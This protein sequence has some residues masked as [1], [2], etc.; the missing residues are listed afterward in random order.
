MAN[1]EFVPMSVGQVLDRTFKLYKESFLRYVAIV[2]V[3][4]V[5][6]TL[7]A[8]LLIGM[9]GGT[10]AANNGE[11]GEEMAVATIIGAVITLFLSIVASALC[12]GA[13]CKSVSESYL[14]REVS[15][16]EAYKFALPKLWT[17]IVAAIMVGLSVMG[18]MI[19][20]IVPG[21]IF[22]LWLLLTTPVIMIENTK[23]TKAM[24]RSKFLVS[25]NLGK[26]FILA[27]CV[28]AI[29]WILGM[30]FGLIATAIA[31]P[32]AGGNAMAS[33]LIQ[34]FG[35]MIGQ[36]L[37]APIASAAYILFY[38]DLRIRKEAFDLEML[39]KSIGSEET[40][41]GAAIQRP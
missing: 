1:V 27:F 14:G 2:A 29:T 36:I 40:S 22:A 38:Y 11:A 16:G 35:S 39:A 23:A 34:Q 31:K 17:L 12:Q 32:M 7:L 30:L 19:L 3:V 37:A 13:L 33:M 20:L 41:I 9:I 21:I 6:I 15:V 28:L 26:A 10:F 18:G 8:L 24:G 25:G 4:Q 5:P